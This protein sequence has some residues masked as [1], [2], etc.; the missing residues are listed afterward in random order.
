MLI[1]DNT[2]DTQHTTAKKFARRWRGPFVITKIHNNSTYE[3]RELDGTKHRVPYTGKRVKL[4][5][6][7]TKFGIENFINNEEHDDLQNS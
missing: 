6:R 2:L 7:R 1:S 5:K 4:F 3:V